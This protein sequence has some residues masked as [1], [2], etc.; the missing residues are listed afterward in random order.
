M[1]EVAGTRVTLRS[2]TLDDVDALIAGQEQDPAS[3]GPG[4]EE[5]RER[6]RRQG[7]RNP[8]L[9]NGGVLAPPAAGGGGVGGGGRGGRAEKR[10]PA[11]GLR[12]RETTLWGV[13]R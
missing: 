13:A 4:G 11:R 2:I 12:D 5:G 8:T 3:F 9:E 1:V 7:E 10:L 6:L